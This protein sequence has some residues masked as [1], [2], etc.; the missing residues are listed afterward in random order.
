MG[1]SGN[2][3]QITRVAVH[4]ALFCALALPVAASETRKK[5]C[6]AT[7]DIVSV[8]MDGRKAGK[9]ADAV[10][11][12]LSSGNTAVEKTYVATVGPL[13]DWVYGL[14]RA[15]L[16]DAVADEFEAQCLNY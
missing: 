16:T 2:F 13:V 10:K 1:M 12:G 4:A 3:G 15:M 6:A 5:S 8:A 11:S 14:D 9:S 7:R